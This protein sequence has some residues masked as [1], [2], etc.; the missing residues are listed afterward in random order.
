MVFF[1]KALPQKAILCYHVGHRCS[2]FIKKML[3]VL[4]VLL[5]LLLLGVVVVAHELGHLVIARMNGVF[6]EA[7]SFGFGNVLFKKKDKRGTEW[8][9]SL[10]PLGGYVKM[11]GDADASSVREVIPDGYT[12]EDM[13]RMSAHRKKPW[14]RLLIAAGGPFANFILAIFVFFS[15]ALVNGMPEYDNSIIVTSEQSIAYKS[16]L[17]TGDTIVKANGKDITKFTDIAKQVASSSG[18]TLELE[19]NRNSVTEEVKVNMVN[20]DGSAATHIGISPK[21]FKYTKVSLMTALTSSVKITYRLACDN[22]KGMFKVA[23]GAVS[24]KNVGGIISIYKVAKESAESGFVSFITMIAT[25]SVIL[26]AVNLLP[27]PVLDGG[28]I[29]VSAIEWVVGRPL[30]Q[31]VINII[32]AIG[33]IAVVG[34]MVLGIWNDLEKM[35][36]FSWLKGVF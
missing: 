31:R 10:F 34:L 4:S 6:C 7:F 14:Q 15:L 2:D 8:R 29:V 5:F 33:L 9:I 36:F 1:V 17:R 22:I 12:E 13:E 25:I 35:R 30:N 16:G 18:K 23:T 27:I 32:F 3:P 20:E 24:S 21:G 26:G 11:L 19:I 28:G